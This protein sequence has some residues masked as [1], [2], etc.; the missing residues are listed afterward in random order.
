MSDIL[1]IKLVNGDTVTQFKPGQ[2]YG[3]DA[4]TSGQAVIDLL[5]AQGHSAEDYVYDNA[6][7]CDLSVLQ[8][9]GTNLDTDITIVDGMVHNSQ[10][11]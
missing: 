7:I 2:N 4:A 10:S 1:V 3:V 9:E 8:I 5:I 6:A 11:E